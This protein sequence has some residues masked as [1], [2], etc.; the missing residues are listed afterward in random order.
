LGLT[1]GY[2]LEVRS[3]KDKTCCTKCNK[4]VQVVNLISHEEY[5]DQMRTRSRTEEGRIR[6][7]DKLNESYLFNAGYYL[8]YPLVWQVKG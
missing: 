5:D 1:K 3:R 4:M 8:Q 7:L 6:K 2:E